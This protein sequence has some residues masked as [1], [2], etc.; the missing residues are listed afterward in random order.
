MT[1]QHL[2]SIQQFMIYKYFL[3]LVLIATLQGKR[4][5]IRQT[6]TQRMDNSKVLLYSTGIYVQYPE[7]NP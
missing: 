3:H 1:L 6:S 7:T 2:V 5:Y 4:Q